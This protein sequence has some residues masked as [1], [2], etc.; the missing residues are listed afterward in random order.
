M[1]DDADWLAAIAQ[2][3]EAQ[4]PELVR[5]RTSDAALAAQAL[6]WL[7][8]NR[9]RVEDD[10]R[11][12]ALAGDRYELGVLLDVGATAAV[13]QAH[14]GKLGRN[15]AIKV[16]RGERSPLLD[17]ILAEARAA[18]EITSDH[19]V[20]VLDVYDADPPFIVMELVGEWEPKRGVLA[21]GASAAA[22]R[23]RSADEAVRWVR[24]VARGVHDAHL[25]NV[26]HRDLKPHNVLITPFS[27]RAQIADFGLA[28]SG[29]RERTG[30]LEITGTPAY[31]APEQAAGLP[32]A[33]D[34]HDLDERAVLV[35]LDVW[36]LGALAYDLLVG[37]APWLGDDSDDSAAS[38]ALEPWERA[39]LATEAL[40]LPRSLPRRLRRVVGKALAI[41]PKQRY[42]TAGE[43]ADDLD[44]YLRR[45][46]TSHDRTRAA[47]VALWCRRNPQLAISIAA[48]IAL[49]AIS[50]G[51]YATIVE[52]RAQRNALAVEAADEQRANE[53]LEQRAKQTHADLTAT[54]AELGAKTSELDRVR[55]ALAD[56]DKEHEALVLANERALASADATTKALADQLT[57]A[58]SERDSATFARQLYEGFW[59]R[60][61]GEAQQASRDRDA[62]L[63]ERDAARTERDQATKD[64][65]AEVDARA[66][67]E[68]E[69][70]RALAERDRAEAIRRRIE[71]D[72]AKL[73]A[74]LA[75][76]R[77]L[78]APTTAAAAVLANITPVVAAGSNAPPHAPTTTSSAAPHAQTPAP[79]PGAGSAS[80]HPAP[81]T[82]ALA[83][84]DPSHALAPAS[85]STAAAGS[86]AAP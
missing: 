26:F 82:T 64:R 72:V 1:K 71:D 74:Q 47:R 35:A 5:A 79:A 51:T 53:A 48:A 40:E 84:T 28:V 14:D 8:A 7:R 65:G 85:T 52:V 57:T 58:H 25:H 42:A 37:H 2:R 56:A 81:A 18:A 61:R 59:N 39:A 11:A 44:A 55:T 69:R 80:P 49:A 54:E 27:R 68:Q 78:P 31:I 45:E 83:G 29:E 21:P 38:G 50:A 86:A 4:W 19:V 10:E 34:P 20:R 46:P 12:P 6:I 22:L 62:A 32:P 33:L 75:A 66:Q 16:F 67:A 36:G 30:A 77:G 24:D 63:A 13:W 17:E 9:E 43:L 73:T 15:V 3:P 70:D 60:A 76:L 23:P 41:D